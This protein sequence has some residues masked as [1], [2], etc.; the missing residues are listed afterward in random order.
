L[1]RS[2][3]KLAK[4][5]D[6]DRTTV[7]ADCCEVGLPPHNR[8]DVT[9]TDAPEEPRDQIVGV[10]DAVG[11]NRYF[12]W[13]DGKFSD[14]GPMLDAAHA[15]HPKLP[16]AVSEYGAGAALTQH[17]ENP[18]ATPINSHGRPHPEEYQE[19]YHEAAWEALKARPYVWGVFIW[20][21]FDFASDSRNE[22]D[23]TDI[24]DKGMISYDRTVAKDAFYFYRAN[25]S[26]QPTLHL[27]GRRFLQ[28]PQTLI[29]VKAYSNA[30]QAHL[31][32]NDHDQGMA[33]CDAG[34]CLWHGVQLS[35]GTNAVRATANIGGGEVSD[36]LQWTVE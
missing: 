35:K 21:M 9:H 13:Y 31:W 29:D 27:V 30:A 24:N 34:I 7:M 33:A 14:F 22:G 11:Y 5:E 17:S 32:I 16:L 20:N 15:R 18:L 4:D 25:W 12:G 26:A 2:L 10:T 1:L 28:R 3:N 36:S 23:S 6:P 19:L 8:Q